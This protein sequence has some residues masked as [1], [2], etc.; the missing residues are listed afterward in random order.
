MRPPRTIGPIVAIAGLVS[1][2]PA[3]GLSQEPPRDAASVERVEEVTVIETVEV[4]DAQG[5]R[6]A[7]EGGFTLLQIIGRNHAAAVHIPI[8]LLVGVLLLEL[9]A[10][11]FPKVPLGRSGL[12]LSLATTAGFIPAALSGFVRSSELFTHAEAPEIVFEHR[13]LMIAAI[14]LFTVA[15]V[16]RLVRKDSLEGALRTVYL[17]LVLLAAVLMAAGG[18]HGGQ[19]VYGERFLPY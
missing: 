9:I 16:L 14:A 1:L 17:A 11:L 10:L 13:N 5:G 7:E 3:P 8:G 6:E 4:V 15:L 12:I 19:L 2:L 18:H